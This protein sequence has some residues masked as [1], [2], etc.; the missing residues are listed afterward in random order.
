MC[1]IALTVCVTCSKICLMLLFF[2]IW[3]IMSHGF[4]LHAGKVCDFSLFT[5][6]ADAYKTDGI[7]EF[8]TNCDYNIQ[9]I[10]QS[11]TG[12]FFSPRFPQEYP[13]NSNCHYTFIGHESERVRIKFDLIMLPRHGTRS[14]LLYFIHI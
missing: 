2:R 5:L 6:I 3:P 12:K 1:N 4:R 7:P 8:G 13:K 10:P 14:V 11:K 9:S